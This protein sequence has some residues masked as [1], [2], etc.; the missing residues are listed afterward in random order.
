M[1]TFYVLCVSLVLGGLAVG[2][3]LREAL[4]GT[5]L[6]MAR[7]P[8]RARP[9]VRQNDWRSFSSRP[10]GIKFRPDL[11]G[12]LPARDI[13]RDRLIDAGLVRLSLFVP[14][15][16]VGFIAKSGVRRRKPGGIVK[17]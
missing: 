8:A 2:L 3:S 5:W 10:S 4:R 7:V 11:N 12:G 17:T 6:R 9:P 13:F 14:S 1:I 16:V 15:A